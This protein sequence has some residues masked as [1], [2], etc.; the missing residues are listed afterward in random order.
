MVHHQQIQL[1]G[2]SDPSHICPPYQRRSSLYSS[3]C[4]TTG[5]WP[6]VAAALVA[7]RAST[8]WDGGCTG[9]AST[10][11]TA[12]DVCRAC[13]TFSPR[14]RCR[15]SPLVP[16]Q[17][18]ENT[19]LGRLNAADR[20]RGGRRHAPNGHLGHGCT[21]AAE[22]ARYTYCSWRALCEAKAR[23]CDSEVTPHRGR[24]RTRAAST[25]TSAPRSRRRDVGRAAAS[26][27][28]VGRR[29]KSQHRRR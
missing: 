12:P 17:G 8:R 3:T 23:G 6:I 16:V 15:P 24:A 5:Q 19:Q 11:W 21:Q 10:L 20:A 7:S 27:K 25:R 29:C 28:E 2:A 1:K 13:Q 22:G 26:A 18:F 4:L 14:P 9:V